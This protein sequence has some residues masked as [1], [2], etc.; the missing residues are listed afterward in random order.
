MPHSTSRVRVSN[1][2]WGYGQGSQWYFPMNARGLATL[3][4]TTSNPQ[5]AQHAEHTPA[6]PLKPAG[7]ELKTFAAA[8]G[9]IAKASEK[10]TQ[11]WPSLGSV[12]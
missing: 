3:S 2:P 8:Q 1:T 6:T 11:I 4:S 5:A 7:M 12:L 9:A 10:N